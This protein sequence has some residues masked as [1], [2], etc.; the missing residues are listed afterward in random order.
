MTTKSQSRPSIWRMPAMLVLLSLVPAMAGVA[1][2]WELSVG[3]VITERN[4]RFFAA[5]LPIVLHILAA[6]P[7]SILGA[8]LFSPS[9]RRRW[10]VWHRSVGCLLVALGM[11]VASTGLW[12]AVFYSWPNGDGEILYVLR[13]VFG[14]AMAIAIVLGI[15]AIRRRDFVAHGAWM[16][17]GYAIGMGAG[18]QVLTHIPYI[19]L[20]G[21]PGEST[22]AVLMGAGWVINV[23]FAEWIIQKGSAR[24]KE[25]LAAISGGAAEFHT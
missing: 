25:R 16:I 11:V 5:P 13:L 17:R 12:M 3:A 8:F 1:R 19:A 23:V 6:I 20:V 7:F 24:S 4:A 9:I 10:P 18:T 21:K 2:L 14:S 15:D 22:R